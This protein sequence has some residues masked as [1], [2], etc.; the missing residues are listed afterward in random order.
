MTLF[1]A[2]LP[3]RG[4]LLRPRLDAASPIRKSKYAIDIVGLLAEVDRQSSFGVL[5]IGILVKNLALAGGLSRC[6]LGHRGGTC[7]VAGL[8]LRDT[9]T[10]RLCG[11]IYK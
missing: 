3:V 10:L 6:F 1:N 7:G 4:E 5:P 2:S 9:I 11:G 8:V